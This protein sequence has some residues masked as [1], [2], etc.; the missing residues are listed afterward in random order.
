[1]RDVDLFVGVCSIGNDPTWGDRGEAPAATYWQTYSFGELSASAMI[2]KAVLSR[3][4]PRLKIA[5]RC[6]I[7]DNFLVVNGQ[8]RTYKIH[9]GSGN[10]LMEPGSTYL[11]IVPDRISGV[12]PPKLF[13]PFEGDSTLSIILSKAFM[14]A[15]DTKIKNPQILTQFKTK[16]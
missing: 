15:E 10:I 2:R 7:K 3:L 12:T 16:S 13:L 11:C 5:D 14:L 1:M 8:I 4:L 9:L 6:S